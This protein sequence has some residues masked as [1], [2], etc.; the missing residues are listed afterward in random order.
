[1]IVIHRK[2]LAARDDETL[3]E[4]VARVRLE[5]HQRGVTDAV[6]ATI[7]SVLRAHP[8]AVAVRVEGQVVTP[9][10]IGEVL[11]AQGKA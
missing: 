6:L 7:V 3:S 9:M 11:A 2:Q 5:L 1:M 4:A 10:S 8:G